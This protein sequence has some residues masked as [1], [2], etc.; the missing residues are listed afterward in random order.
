[1]I[2]DLVSP[3]HI[4]SPLE[5][6]E[7]AASAMARHFHFLWAHLETARDIKAVPQRSSASQAEAAETAGADGAGA[8]AACRDCQAAKHLHKRCNVQ[9]S[10]CSFAQPWPP[11][12]QQVHLASLVF[13][14][15]LCQ[16]K[17]VL[18]QTPTC[19]CLGPLLAQQRASGRGSP[20]WLKRATMSVISTT[21]S[22]WMLVIILARCYML[23]IC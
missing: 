22:P 9:R 14:E 20:R 12:I 5:H 8:A 4:A 19:P 6:P 10:V 7:V 2:L 16:M 13:G 3:V 23:R 17:H 1:M 11:K 21:P 15:Q 18:A